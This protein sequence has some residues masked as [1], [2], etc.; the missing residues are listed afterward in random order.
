GSATGLSP[1]PIF[2]VES[3]V[4]GAR[5]GFSVA[6]AGDVNGDG[7]SDVLFAAPFLSDDQ[8]SEGRVYLFTGSGQ[9]L[10]T[11]PAWSTEADLAASD[12]GTS[13][14]PGDFNGDGY[15]DVVVG[16]PRFDDGLSIDQGRAF[17]YFGSPSGLDT[18]IDWTVEGSQGGCRFGGCVASAGDVNG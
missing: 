2:T 5:L 11:T 14:A 16:A 6:T 10:H 1:T 18:V 17:L 7:F 8:T 3:N 12:Y 13:V 9:G 15:T 4:A